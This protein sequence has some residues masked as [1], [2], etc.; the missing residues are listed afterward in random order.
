MGVPIGNGQPDQPANVSMTDLEASIQ[1]L[2][3][4]ASSDPPNLHA[5]AMLRLAQVVDGL[6]KKVDTLSGQLAQAQQPQAPS[7]ADQA[8]QALEDK[9]AGQAEQVVSGGAAAT[10]APVATPANG[11]AA[12][13]TPAAPA[14]TSGAAAAAP[15]NGGSTGGSTDTGSAPAAP[16]GA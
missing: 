16:V 4:L 12:A 8:E 9:I 5:K 7:A 11:S 10:T 3:N 2:S 13:A 1:E 6:L 14:D 15:A